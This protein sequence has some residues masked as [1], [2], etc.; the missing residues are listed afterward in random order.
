[1]PTNTNQT[2]PEITPQK[3][4]LEGTVNSQKNTIKDAFCSAFAERADFLCWWGSV[5]LI[6]VLGFFAI[7]FI[8][9]LI[10]GCI[11]LSEPKYAEC[12]FS[13]IGGVLMGFF[14]KKGVN[15]VSPKSSQ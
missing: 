5:L 1:M 2:A 10:R 14:G 3:P 7:A 12:L 4:E 8:Y 13:W 11:L 15:F 6:L 9:A